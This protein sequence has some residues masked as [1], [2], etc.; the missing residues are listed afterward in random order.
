MSKLYWLGPNCHVSG[1]DASRR[2]TTHLCHEANT[3]PSGSGHTLPDEAG[4]LPDRIQGMI[5]EAENPGLPK[6]K[7]QT[8]KPEPNTFNFNLLKYLHLLLKRK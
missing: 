6:K 5:R 3:G 1:F 4:P 7:K 2:R 8:K